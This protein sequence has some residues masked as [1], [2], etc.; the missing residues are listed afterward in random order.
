MEKL[1][2][3]QIKVIGDDIPSQSNEKRFED[4]SDTRSKSLITSD[5]WLNNNNVVF[6][7]ND[8]D[9]DDNNDMEHKNNTLA[10]ETSSINIHTVYQSIKN[11][12]NELH[13]YIICNAVLVFIWFLFLCIDIYYMIRCPTCCEDLNDN[14]S[15]SSSLGIFSTCMLVFL[16]SRYGFMTFIMLFLWRKLHKMIQFLIKIKHQQG[17]YLQSEEYSDNTQ[18]M[19]QCIQNLMLIHQAIKNQTGKLN[20]K[21]ELKNHQSPS[22]VN[23][24]KI[25]TLHQTFLPF[26]NLPTT[27]GL[28]HKGLSAQQPPNNKYI[29]LISSLD[30]I[31]LLTLIIYGFM[32]IGTQSIH[33]TQ[34]CNQFFT[35]LCIFL[36]FLIIFSFFTFI[37]W[38][39][40]FW[41]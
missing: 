16:V 20:E 4:I 26:L 39:V 7:N 28:T 34:I 41:R 1:K 8:D 40:Y 17:I 38:L 3:L 19:G 9:D 35:F 6:N 12:Q 37:M 2:K 13:K 15:I 23:L 21:D 25:N 24:E 33:L 18:Q 30:I 31:P 14:T 10:A 36:I 5:S 11:I 32:F 22:I 29:R 27:N